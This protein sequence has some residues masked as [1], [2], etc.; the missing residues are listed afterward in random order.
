VLSFFIR[1]CTSC[2]GHEDEHISY[3]VSYSAG[4]FVYS[5]N[6]PSPDDHGIKITRMLAL[7]LFL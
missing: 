6:D 5:V 7:S 2:W 3:M 4:S 1:C